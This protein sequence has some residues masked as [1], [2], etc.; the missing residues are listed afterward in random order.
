[1]LARHRLLPSLACLRAFETVARQRNFSKAAAELNLT[2]GA[3]SRQIGQLEAQLGV[4]LLA[5]S[6]R[7]VALTDAG[8]AYLQRI[9]P[10]LAEIEQASLS[11]ITGAQQSGS[12]TIGIL[13]TFGNRWLIPRLPDFTRQHPSIVLNIV[14]R[15]NRFDLDADRVD[16]AIHFGDATWDGARLQKLMQEEVAPLASPS[17]FKKGVPARPSALLRQPLLQVASR[18]QAWSDWCQAAGVDA[19]KL[20]PGPTFEQFSMLAQAAI[21]G[22]GVALLPLFLF[23]EELKSGALIEAGPR[24][25]SRGRYYV[26]T[27]LRRVQSAAATTFVDWLIAHAEVGG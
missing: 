20:Q 18:P 15:A 10:A 17:L 5:R 22:L 8:G 26:V 23:E 4:A 3:V 2:Q 12:L 25:Q 1:M 24:V 6:S 7:S 9:Q 14:S 16:V 21:A 11:A 13:P 19:T 27:P